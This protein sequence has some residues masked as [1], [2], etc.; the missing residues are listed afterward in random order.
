MNVQVDVQCS[1]LALVPKDG[2]VRNYMRVRHIYRGMPLHSKY[3]SRPPHDPL[4]S[5]STLKAVE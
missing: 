2:M 4:L 5:G 3:L 1:T